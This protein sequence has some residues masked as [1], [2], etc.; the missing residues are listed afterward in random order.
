MLV[1]YPMKSEQQTI[2][3]EKNVFNQTRVR[4]VAKTIIKR[5]IIQITAKSL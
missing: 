1:S 5:T 4:S 3:I 2:L